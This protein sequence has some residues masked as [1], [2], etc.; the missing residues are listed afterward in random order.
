MSN[1]Q[2]IISAELIS[3]GAELLSGRTVNRHAHTLGGALRELGIELTRDTTLPDD[4]AAI[5]QAVVDAL[6][7]APVVFV[8][9]GLGP[10]SDDVTRDALADALG[11]GMAVHPEARAHLDAWFAR[12]GRPV[13]ESALRQALVLDGALPLA[14][15]AGIAPGQRLERDGR[16]I[17]VLPGPPREFKAILDDHVLPDL[18]R[19]CAGQQPVLELVSMFAGLGESDL[20]TWVSAQNVPSGIVEGYC[21]GPGRLEFRLSTREDNLVPRVRDLME[22]ACAQYADTLFSR[23]RATLE[24]SVASSLLAAE[25]S[26]AVAES[27]TGG[28]LG[29]GLTALPG[30]SGWFHGGV[31]CYANA[32]KERDLGVSPATLFNHGAVSEPCAREMAEGVRARFGTTWGVSVTGIAGPGGGTET[33]PVGTVCIAVAG[34]SGTEARTHKFNGDRETVREFARQRAVNQ[35][36]RALRSQVTSGTSRPS[37]SST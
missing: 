28:M 21:A 19:R 29:A 17:Y 35:L 12:T 37:G 25:Q 32:S 22:R 24:E 15:R 11:I 14:N 31:I 6:A 9:G 1:D 30:S 27:C 8:S 26:L 36:W 4:R 2:P 20:Q 3:T 23:E 18:R 10:T 13:N 34:P 7:R 16:V 33:K 5:R